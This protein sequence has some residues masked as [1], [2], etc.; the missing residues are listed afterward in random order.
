[1]PRRVGL[2]S[3]VGDPLPRFPRNPSFCLQI[4]L[5]SPPTRP[6]AVAASPPS[7]LLLPGL[8]PPPSGLPK[9]M[10][11]VPNPRRRPAFHPPPKDFPQVRARVSSTLPS[12]LL[13]EKSRKQ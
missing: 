8:R 7:S 12:L 2:L 11:R 6:E 10:P 9:P 1:M 4:Q 3:C 13:M 5:P